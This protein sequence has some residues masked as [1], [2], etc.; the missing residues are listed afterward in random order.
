M[1]ENEEIFPR[2]ALRAFFS[3]IF[4]LLYSVQLTRS[5]ECACV[6]FEWPHEITCLSVSIFCGKDVLVKLTVA[7]HRDQL[8]DSSSLINAPI[9]MS[10]DLANMNAHIFFKNIIYFSNEHGQKEML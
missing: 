7:P 6:A 3:L 1:L 10:L 8:D 9:R 5:I 4:R 2:R